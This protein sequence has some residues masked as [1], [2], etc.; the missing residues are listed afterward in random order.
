MPEQFPGSPIA[1]IDSVFFDLDGVVYRGKEAIPGAVESLNVLSQIRKLGYI[2]NNASRSGNDVAEHLRSLGIDCEPNQVVTSVQAAG[3]LLQT[4]V[5]APATVL[6]VGSPALES[7]IS[8]RGYTTTRTDTPEVIAVVQGYHPDVAWRDLAEAAFA[9]GRGTV[10]IATNTDW[11]MPQE[12]GIA[13]GNGTLVSAVHTAAGPLATVAGKPEL[14]IFETAVQRFRSQA[15]L[16]VGDRLDTDI[17]GG[18]RAGMKTVLVLTGIDQPKQVV[19][20]PDD[21]QPTYILNNLTE[22]FQPYPEIV[23]S[24][25]NGNPTVTVREASL[26]IRDRD[27]IDVLSA[28]EDRTDLLRAACALIWPTKRAIYGFYVPPEIFNYRVI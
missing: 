5:P 22:L 14:P 20:A 10:W 6:I 28:G 23:H 25:H 8:G 15:S 1:G 11:T 13:P 17:L 27:Y 16:M 7:E 12:R 18:N 26:M 24:E 3:E 4:M 21:Y 9:V 2:T 19:A